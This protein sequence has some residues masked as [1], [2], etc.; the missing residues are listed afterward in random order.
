MIIQRVI[1]GETH[2]IQL[3]STELRKAAELQEE[4]DIYAEFDYRF[5]SLHEDVLTELEEFAEKNKHLLLKTY[6]D[7]IAQKIFEYEDFAGAI[8]ELRHDFNDYKELTPLE[9]TIRDVK[10]KE[11]T[12]ELE[13]AWST[14]LSLRHLPLTDKEA[15][16]LEI[17]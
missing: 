10:S 5:Q 15:I 8:N 11:K 3:T 14:H 4:F 6:K 9:Q 1:N 2:E 13:K 17:F 16:E 7:V 12:D